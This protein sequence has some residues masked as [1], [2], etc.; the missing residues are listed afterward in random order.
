MNN[1][2]KT[3]SFWCS[4]RVKKIGVVLALL[5]LPFFFYRDFLMGKVFIWEDALFLSYPHTNYILKSLANGRFPLWLANFCN[6]LPY[7]GEPKPIF[8]PFTLLMLPFVSGGQLPF[9]VY[10]WNLVLQIC[11]GGSFMYLFLKSHGL[12]PLTALV[13]VTV[14]C[15]SGFMSL[16]FI[17][18]AFIQGYIWLPLELWLVKK[19]I[20]TGAWK[21]YVWLAV[22]L[23]VAIHGG[24]PQIPLY[25]GYLLVAYWVFCFLTKQ[26]TEVENGG[27]MV[28]RRSLGELLR[29]AGVFALVLGLCAVVMLP[30]LENLRLSTRGQWG[31]R[32]MADQS[33]PLYYLMHFLAP[34]FFGTTGVPGFFGGGAA[35]TLPFWGADRT[36]LEVQKFGWGSWQYWEFGSYGGQITLLA[37]VI[38]IFNIQRMQRRKEILFFLSMAIAALWF[39]LGRYGGVFN[40]LYYVLPG[41]SMFRNPSRM[42]CVLDFCLA[43][44]SALMVEAVAVE[45]SLKV[46][47]P[48]LVLGGVYLVALL[49]FAGLVR[50]L[51][52]V[53]IGIGKATDYGLIQL[54]VSVLFCA[55]IGV[56]LWRLNTESS[57]RFQAL[58][59]SGIVLMT[60]GD[61][62]YAFGGFHRGKT[63]P[64]EFVGDPQRLLPRFAKLEKEIG[65]FRF[66]QLR[67]ASHQQEIV[68]CLAAPYFH[69]ELSYTGGYFVFDVRDMTSFQKI[70]HLQTKM[71]IQN[72]RVIANYDSK[73]GGVQ[74]SLY[75]NSLPRVAFYTKYKAYDTNEKLLAALDSE[76]L[77]Y[78]DVIGVLKSDATLFASTMDGASMVSNLAARVMLRHPVPEEYRIQYETTTP[79]ILFLSETFYPGWKTQNSKYKLIKVFG[80]FTGIVVPEA[81]K[82]EIILKFCPKSF[83]LGA[84]ISGSVVCGLLLLGVV[85][86]LKNR[87]YRME[88]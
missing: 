32:E 74:L 56:L 88:N 14:F 24:H 79:G 31:F 12:R 9:L 13:G 47:K 64:A 27:M 42:A 18:N 76:V 16:H 23:A 86:L 68:F 11:F 22:A 53:Q 66:E 83:R 36:S 20:S 59:L 46:K 84:V 71:D 44:L 55:G 77:P 34:N 62:Y 39:M 43:V 72:V 2:L 45:K 48:L 15:F 50:S 40:V 87:F 51:V 38:V 75:T 70:Q 17:H 49:G 10:Q 19:A 28:V 69:D 26:K 80:A 52:P 81:G 67:D 1:E 61:F 33:F 35:P 7:M 54:I 58:L 78:H 73:Q 37:L 29:M 5:A 57:H 60:F 3:T 65:P 6:G 4:S 85:S 8:Y 63:N 82:G 30:A 21:F 41:A 25:T